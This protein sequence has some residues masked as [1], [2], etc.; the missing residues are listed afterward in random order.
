MPDWQQSGGLFVGFD[1][2][3]LKIGDLT[4]L[5]TGRN[6][7]ADGPTSPQHLDGDGIITILDARI[8][9]TLYSIYIIF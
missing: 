3:A 9:V 6:I 5:T 4:I 8:S 1:Q 2:N 7:P